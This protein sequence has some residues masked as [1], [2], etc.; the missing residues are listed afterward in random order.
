VSRAAAPPPVDAGECPQSELRALHRAKRAMTVRIS[1]VITCLVLLVGTLAYVVMCNGQRQITTME[2]ADTIA[3]HDGVSPPEC[4]WLYTERDGVVTGVGDNQPAGFPRTADL[5]QAAATGR[6]VTSTVDAN[7]TEY[8]VRTQLDGGAVVQAVFDQRFQLADR[9]SLFMGL[10]V[11]EL[12]GLLTAVITGFVLAGRVIEPLAEALRRQR[13]F[14]ADASHELRAPLTQLHTRA[15]LLNRLVRREGGPAKVGDEVERL[16]AGTRQLGEVVE[17][18]LLSAQLRRDPAQLSVV[19]LGAIVADAVAADTPRADSAGLSLSLRQDDTAHLVPGISTALRRVVAALLDN[20]LGHTPP[21]GAI[22]LDLKAVDNG[23]VLQLTVADTGVGFD[24][25][26]ATRIFERF[27]RGEAGH[28]RRFGLG[29]AL[30][31][32]V[33][34]SHNGTI[35]AR[36]EPGHG[37][38]FT[39][40]LPTH[41]PSAVPTPRPGPVGPVQAVRRVG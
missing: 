36:G 34:I 13:R 6:P 33:V 8:S 14:V 31:N 29:L 20:A 3:H 16:V 4:L 19:D 39:L 22:D 23:R 9:R 2:L 38:T 27:A 11:A 32:E 10:L 30:V 40:R 35:A 1:L 17:D 41:Q 37:A 18:L 28:G 26:D 7:G 15:Q 21:G 25:Q 12:L 5:R 24:Q